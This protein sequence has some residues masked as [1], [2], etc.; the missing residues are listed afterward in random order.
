[1]RILALDHLFSAVVCLFSSIG[2]MQ[3]EPELR[4]AIAAMAAH[5]EVGGVLLVEPWFTPQQWQPNTVH[6][7]VAAGEGRHVARMAYSTGSE[8]T[9]VMEMHYLYGQD[10]SGVTY[11]LDRH[12]M[13]LFTTGQYES[14]FTT[15]GITEI[16]WVAGWERGRDRLI[17]TKRF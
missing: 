9:S 4:Q 10:G 3:S 13:T 6:H 2:Y 1:M 7:T 5:V 15:A 11:W 16:Q 8:T 14:A 17:G 12:V